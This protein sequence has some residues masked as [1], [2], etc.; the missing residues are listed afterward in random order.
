MKR[1]FLLLLPLIFLGLKNP[2][3]L[4]NKDWISSDPLV[5][6][7]SSLTGITFLYHSVD[8]TTMWITEGVWY[9]KTIRRAKAYPT[10][11]DYRLTPSTIECKINFSTSGL[12]V[13]KTYL[14]NYQLKGKRL[15]LSHQGK[16]AIY[17]Q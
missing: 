2:P 13:G 12:P 15:E 3:G 5:I 1:A 11:F 17:R 4:L 6:D 7:G 10:S 9:E 16:T 8:T 14:L